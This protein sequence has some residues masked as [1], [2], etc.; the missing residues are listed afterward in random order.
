MPSGHCT[1][2]RTGAV[3][4]QLRWLNG[5]AQSDPRLVIVASHDEEQRQALVKEGVLGGRFE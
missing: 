1:R 2:T 3:L 5:L 4:A